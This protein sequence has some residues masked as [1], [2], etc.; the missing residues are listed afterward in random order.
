MNDVIHCISSPAVYANVLFKPSPQPGKLDTPILCI[1]N[2]G[3][4]SLPGCGEGFFLYNTPS[5][6]NILCYRIPPY[7]PPPI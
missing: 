5:M 6:N 7:P 4:Y 3:V 1:H 2:I